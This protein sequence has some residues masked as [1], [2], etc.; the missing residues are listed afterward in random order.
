MKNTK[1]TEPVDNEAHDQEDAQAW[2]PPRHNAYIGLDVHKDTI[3]VSVAD[4]VLIYEEPQYLVS[5]RGSK[6]TESCW[7]ARRSP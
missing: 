1:T 4:G 3:A 5:G 2:T 7:F 6:H